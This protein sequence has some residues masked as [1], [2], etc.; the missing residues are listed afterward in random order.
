MQTR[1]YYGPPLSITREEIE[2]ERRFPVKI[3]PSIEALWDEF[4][5]DFAALLRENNQAG[6]KTTVILPVGPFDYK[7]A[8]ALLNRERIS[9]ANLVTFN[10]DEFCDE[11]GKLIA[12][13][14]PLSFRAYMKREFHD[15]LAPELRPKPENMVFPDSESPGE[16]GARI[17]DEGGVEVCYGG[18][19]I[20]G[21]YAFNVPPGPDEPQD[22][23]YFE[24]PTRLV[25][26]TPETRTQTA[27]G[28]ASGDIAS[29]PPMAVTIG[30]AEIMR[31]AKMRVYLMRPWQSAVVRRVF[32][33][34]VT[35]K[36]PA[37]YLQRHPD[38]RVV[39]VEFVAQ[40]PR[41][42]PG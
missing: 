24:L 36:Y 34:P 7:R 9:C 12:W 16:L 33:G 37:S 32:Y 3:V 14:H 41:I 19:G 13:D 20:D 40:P 1:T 30:M 21:H 23:S 31:S 6:R 17:T 38:L 5:R 8:A 27:V 10:M 15:V 18:I 22:D 11:D 25:R 28:S 35:P 42:G 2:G 4:A 26:L 29:V 39:M